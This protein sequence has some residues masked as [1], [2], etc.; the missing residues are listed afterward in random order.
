MNTCATTQ[1]SYVCGVCVCEGGDRVK[2][3]Q[4]GG[5]EDALYFDQAGGVIL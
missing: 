4:E 5:Y 2:Q 3:G 1:A